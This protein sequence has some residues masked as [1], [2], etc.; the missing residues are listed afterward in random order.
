MSKRSER[1]GNPS[2][3]FLGCDYSVIEKET[4][5]IATCIIKDTAQILTKELKRLVQLKEEEIIKR[6]Y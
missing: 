6:I 5:E 3:N 1:G 4:A 2:K